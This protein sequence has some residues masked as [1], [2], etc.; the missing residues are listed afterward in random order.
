MQVVNR[1]LDIIDRVAKER[2][3]IRLKEISSDLDLPYS[4]THRLV[5][6]LE[7]REYLEHDP[8]SRRY[9]IGFKVLELHG[10]LVSRLEIVDQ[11]TPIMHELR[12]QL[13]EFVHL[14][15]LVGHE[16]MYLKS[17]EGTRQAGFY[18]PPNG[19]RAPAHCTSL[20]K[21]ILA[22][23]PKEEIKAILT[24]SALARLTPNTITTEDELLADLEKVEARGYAVDDM[25]YAEGV[26]CVGAPVFNHEGKVVA[27]ISLAAPSMRFPE[28]EIEEK[29]ALVAKA[30]RSISA[31]L[32]QTNT[33]GAIR[34]DVL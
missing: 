19:H 27:A 6:L 28:H 23:L 17:I 8:D 22:Y 7:K 1:I 2:E 34:S 15:R 3:G 29:G 24:A 18:T 25:E 30:A 31:R 32:G 33:S 12:E 4:T 10:Q 13:G 21:A 9:F 26:R 11:A 14:A 20:G 5:T 16:V